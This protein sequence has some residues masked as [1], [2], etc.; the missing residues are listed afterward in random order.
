MFSQNPHE[1]SLRRKTRSS[2]RLAN[3]GAPQS[4][5]K[6][7]PPQNRKDPHDSVPWE[8]EGESPRPSYSDVVS[9]EPFTQNAQGSW[10][11]NDRQSS[12]ERGERLQRSL[13]DKI[14]SAQPPPAEQ[15]WQ[16]VTK[17]NRKNHKSDRQVS[18]DSDTTTNKRTTVD[19]G[20]RLAPS[21]Q[22]KTTGSSLLPAAEI[23]SDDAIQRAEKALTDKERARIARRYSKTTP[24]EAPDSEA[25][26]SA[27]V[28]TS[29]GKGADPSN[30]GKAGIKPEEAN[31]AVQQ[32]LLDQYRKTRGTAL[33]NIGTSS[34]ST[35]AAEAASKARGARHD[36][37]RLQNKPSGT[38]DDRQT[39]PRVP[40]SGTSQ[41]QP[42]YS[43]MGTRPSSQI[44]TTS[45]VGRTLQKF[46]HLMDRAEQAGGSPS[47]SSSSSSDD[48]P[49]P[50]K[51]PDTNHPTAKNTRHKPKTKNKTRKS[52]LKPIPPLQ[53]DGTADLRLYNR[54]VTEG[55]TYLIDGDVPPERQVHILSY[56][57]GG[58]AYDFFVQKI[59]ADFDDWT[60]QE[61]YEKLFDYCFPVDYRA[62]Q[63]AVLNRTYQ[64]SKTVLEYKYELEEKFNIL[65]EFT[66]QQ[67]V[68]KL[69]YG[70]RR[71]IQ[72][73]LWQAGLNPETSSWEDVVRHAEIREISDNV[74]AD[75][76]SR[77]KI[78]ARPK[79]RTA[80][81]RG[82]TSGT[83]FESENGGVRARYQTLGSRSFNRE[84][85]GDRAH[86]P[87]TFNYSRSQSRPGTGPRFGSRQPQRDFT[88]RQ[89]GASQARTPSNSPRPTL[90]DKERQELQAAGKCFN[91]KEPGHMSR[92]CPRRNIVQGSASKPP[93]LP[94]YN[95]EPIKEPSDEDSSEEVEVM[96]S[97]SLGMINLQE[98]HYLPEQAEKFDPC[99]YWTEYSP[100]S[101]RRDKL[102]DALAF[103][104]QENLDWGL[105]Y[106]GDQQL[107]T[108]IGR[109]LVVRA[110][111]DSHIIYDRYYLT[112]VAIEDKLLLDQHFSL[113]KW[114]ANILIENLENLSD[115]YIGER[116]YTMADAYGENA[117]RVLRSGIRTDYPTQNPSI[118]NEFRFD[119]VQADVGEWNIH[120]EDF[121]GDP[122]R[123]SLVELT[124]PTLDLITWYSNRR[125]G[126]LST[127]SITK[128]IKSDPETQ[129]LRII[130][131]VLS[132]LINISLKQ[133]SLE[134]LLDMRE[135]DEMQCSS[136]SAVNREPLT[137]EDSL[138]PVMRPMRP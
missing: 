47:D 135:I 95:I 24:E 8:S 80:N 34:K 39:L 81:M 77:P 104:A 115:P 85:Q 103:S 43:S 109:F 42:S 13:M 19:R 36:E 129:C 94:N 123:V 67:K 96:D 99:D 87:R 18:D 33:K 136:I 46:K 64:N 128:I 1:F 84:R 59:G 21:S 107:E 68:V 133:L 53:Y 9:G 86:S 35:K 56:Y 101:L 12:V 111:Q 93:G 20:A 45:Y 63:R 23:V 37:P 114:Y 6:T 134:N 116:L 48:E 22:T 75:R 17:E 126:K 73:G 10:G 4:S 7:P 16:T 61:F 88:P 40:V 52:K 49:V 79:N 76:D 138:T 28:G 14:R 78:T 66:N 2:A 54:F 69:W 110:D 25:E 5:P 90:S 65:S 125:Y 60:L 51:G 98:P 121:E 72:Q 130:T 117:K 71:S 132:D 29:K 105:P 106:P 30:W 108:N 50:P 131:P 27:G 113:G 124:N 41:R 70:L 100:T 82:G 118:D 97:L 92:H 112:C 119:V 120:D 137:L 127:P 31:E 44:P 32:Q 102:G 122:I 89:A 91:C 26:L 74:V 57:L 3:E 11:S 38:P 55:T 15:P 62:Q 58:R 83:P